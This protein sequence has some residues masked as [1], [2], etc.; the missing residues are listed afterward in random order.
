MTI[1]RVDENNTIMVVCDVLHLWTQQ[2]GQN[3]LGDCSVFPS[4]KPNFR[5]QCKFLEEIKIFNIIKLWT[6]KISNTINF[7]ACLHSELHGCSKM[8]NHLLWYYWPPPKPWW[9]PPMWTTFFTFF[10]ENVDLL[11]VICW[12][13]IS[14]WDF[15]LPLIGQ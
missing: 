10:A 3:R 6:W 14:E 12:P 15:E 8:C 2:L 13:S 1:G 4:K 7:T 5:V 11:S 9:T